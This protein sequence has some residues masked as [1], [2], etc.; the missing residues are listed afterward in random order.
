MFSV[1]CSL[2]RYGVLII[3]AFK[4]F[5]STILVCRLYLLVFLFIFLSLSVFLNW[6][7]YNICVARRC[8][9]VNKTRF[10]RGMRDGWFTLRNT[11]V[12]LVHTHKI[13][14]TCIYITIHRGYSRIYIYRARYYTYI[15]NI[16][17][18]SR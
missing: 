13:T 15:H 6:P 2:N 9:H 5:T 18:T 10:V 1:H 7:P 4:Q 8:K 16:V 14:Y 11:C 12:F 17:P 3:W